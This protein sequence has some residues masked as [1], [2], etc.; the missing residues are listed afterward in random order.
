MQAIRRLPGADLGRL[1]TVVSRLGS[2]PDR[3]IESLEPSPGETRKLLLALGITRTPH[4]I[5]M[6]EPTNHMDLPS[7]R[8]LEESLKNCPCSL[9]LVSHDRAFLKALTT[10]TWSIVNTRRCGRLRLVNQP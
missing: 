5:V 9:L 2:S 7:I 6:D 8:C 10:K 3:V 1:M 4:L